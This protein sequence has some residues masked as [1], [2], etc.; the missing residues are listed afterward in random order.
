[1]H[2]NNKTHTTL[3]TKYV[4]LVPQVPPVD[5]QSPAPYTHTHTHTHPHTLTLTHMKT[6]RHAYIHHS[7]SEAMGCHYLC[8]EPLV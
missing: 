2:R 7:N 3:N 6:N 1:M 4:Q 8:H 5:Q